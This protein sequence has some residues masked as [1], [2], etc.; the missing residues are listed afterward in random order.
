MPRFYSIK[1]VVEKDRFARDPRHYR[2]PFCP[3]SDA[4][5]INPDKGDTGVY[6]CF[7]CGASGSGAEYLVETEGYSMTEALEAFGI[8]A[9]EEKSEDAKAL[10]RERQ[11]R[12]DQEAFERRQERHRF[13]E[14]ERLLEYLT[15]TERALYGLC[16]SRQRQYRFIC[17]ESTEHTRD[18]WGRICDC[19]RYEYTFRERKPYEDPPSGSGNIERRMRAT[20]TADFYPTDLLWM[21]RKRE[22]LMDRA[23]RRARREM[24]E[25]DA[26]DFE[27]VTGS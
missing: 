27:H 8:K 26:L 10:W 5:S 9:P 2:C 22:E 1:D 24:T 15:E 6:Y 20:L 17:G 18:P 25:A 16:C 7:S 21:K 11:E 3:S 14:R 19:G 13:V 23:F 4:L 12:R